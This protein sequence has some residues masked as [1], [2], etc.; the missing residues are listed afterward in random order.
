MKNRV[1]FGVLAAGA[2]LA[3]AS[4][5]MRG[6]TPA[7]PFEGEPEIVA[8]TFSSAW[9]AACRIL[10]PKLARVI[11]QFADAPVK[12]V[13]YDFTFGQRDDIRQAAE[14]D[15]LAALYDKYEGATGFTALFDPETGAVLAFLTSGLTEKALAAEI[16]EALAIASAPDA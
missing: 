14:A 9:C 1:F 15:G 2:A 6:S 10:E 4:N 11:P 16:T 13:D 8:A 5:Q 12:F 7:A 3:A